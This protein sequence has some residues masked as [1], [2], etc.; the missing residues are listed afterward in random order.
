MSQ[1]AS[2]NG[3]RLI[4]QVIGAQRG[5]RIPD[6]RFGK[7]PTNKSRPLRTN[8]RCII[9]TQP[10]LFNTSVRKRSSARQPGG[11]CITRLGARLRAS[12]HAEPLWISCEHHVDTRDIY[13]YLPSG[14]P[15]MHLFNASISPMSMTIAPDSLRPAWCPRY[16]RALKQTK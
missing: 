2:R 6:S 8:A 10:H 11:P 3:A 16:R 14:S 15:R 5:A 9:Y 13:I 7:P 4:S 12:R 1:G